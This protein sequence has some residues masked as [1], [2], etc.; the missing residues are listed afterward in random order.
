MEICDKKKELFMRITT[1][2]SEFTYNA[3][4]MVYTQGYEE[5]EPGHS[6][7]PAVRKSYMFHY[8]T[9]GKGTYTVDGKVYHLK[10]GDIFFIEPGNEVSYQADADDPWGYGWVGL[11]GA[12]AESYLKRTSFFDCPVARYDKS[13]E[14]SLMLIDL[15][16]A[17]AL[18]P[19]IRDLALNHVLYKLL[20]FLVTNFPAARLQNKD[21]T[22]EYISRTME[23]CLSRV[24]APVS[25]QEAAS[26]LG[27]DRS[28]LSRLFKKETGISLKDYIWK[29]KE[30][31]AC[32]LLRTTSL[33]IH[34]IARSVGFED[35]LYFSK[36]F[37][38]KLKLSPREYRARSLQTPEQNRQED[39]PKTPPDSN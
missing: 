26:F 2:S 34:V 4:V 33:P 25:V 17:Y 10:K 7:G 37:A 6:F 28:Y 27:L 24:D 11:T 9:Q 15:Q 31:E 20:A 5:C 21:K 22:K 38:K 32:R 16:R 39:E 19:E 3:D 30:E 1:N 8:I 23:Y 29:T 18:K 35:S 36:N 12:H 13:D 14:L